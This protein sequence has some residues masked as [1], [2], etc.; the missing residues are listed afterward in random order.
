MDHDAAGCSHSSS[1]GSSRSESKQGGS[2]QGGSQQGEA[3]AVSPMPM[4]GRDESLAGKKEPAVPEEFATNAHGTLPRGLLPVP[5]LRIPGI[6]H[7]TL[8]LRKSRMARSPT[9][10][11]R[12][13]KPGAK[14]ARSMRPPYWL[15]LGAIKDPGVLPETPPVGSSSSLS[16]EDLEA[17][18]LGLLGGQTLGE[19]GRPHTGGMLV[20]SAEELAEKN[21]VADKALLKT[22][23]HEG[24]V[25]MNM[26]RARREDGSGTAWAPLTNFRYIVNAEHQ[27]L[28]RIERDIEYV[29]G[30]RR[31][32]ASAGNHLAHLRSGEMVTA[33]W[34]VRD[35]YS[36]ER[37]EG[38]FEYEELVG[39]AF[40]VSV[41][42]GDV[43]RA[44]H[45]WAP[46]PEGESLMQAFSRALEIAASRLMYLNIKLGA[47]SCP[48][49]DRDEKKAATQSQK[50]R[51][52]I[53]H[54]QKIID[55]AEKPKELQ[56]IV[57]SGALELRGR[58]ASSVWS[59][60]YSK[61]ADDLRLVISRTWKSADDRRKVA[62]KL[63]LSGALTCIELVDLMETCAPAEAIYLPVWS[64]FRGQPCLLNYRIDV[65]GDKLLKSSTMETMHKLSMLPIDA[66]VGYAPA[67]GYLPVAT[68]NQD[69]FT[70]LRTLWPKANK[71]ALDV[72]FTKVLRAGARTV[73]DLCALITEEGPS[74]CLL[75]ESSFFRGRSCMLNFNIDEMGGKLFSSSTLE[76][77]YSRAVYQTMFDVSTHSPAL[78]RT[79]SGAGGNTS[80]STED[81]R[82]QKALGQEK[83]EE[84]R[85]RLHLQSVLD[86]PSEQSTAQIVFKAT[87]PAKVIRLKD[88]VLHV[89]FSHDCRLMAM[90]RADGIVSIVAT[91]ERLEHW[92]PINSDLRY[93]HKAV[94]YC[95]F[96]PPDSQ[97]YLPE[98]VSTLLSWS[99]RP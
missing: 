51:L 36:V 34:S 20:E 80:I 77:I 22:A 24:F 8:A 65:N 93:H 99:P 38:P 4:G 95:S 7:M 26:Y 17:R 16:L 58:D 30:T 6:T 76:T 28:F 41:K 60:G 35:V 84:T 11:A 3:D 91:A 40:S 25:V 66:E 88:D 90:A 81:R 2:Q 87:T 57:T 29:P 42:L 75:P 63:R 48:G 50:L 86:S 97:S 21:R 5:P 45:L 64:H 43:T 94:K 18:L 82:M 69:V 74:G 67:H 83:A 92:K 14:T 61:T 13:N 27:L 56:G 70:I 32:T 52:G 68:E 85:R 59:Q 54:K 10:T 71:N 47:K 44:L 19:Q 78:R 46:G 15:G 37:I 23:A 12:P 98:Y 79:R 31:P 53:D 9:K 1:Q 72:T 49:Q 62:E 33:T 39:C 89:A 55:I 73:S 96:R